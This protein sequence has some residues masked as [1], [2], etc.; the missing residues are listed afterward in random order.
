[1][2]INWAPYVGVGDCIVFIEQI[3]NFESYSVC[4]LSLFSKFPI[5][6]NNSLYFF[7]ISRSYISV[8]TITVTK[9][10]FTGKQCV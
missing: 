6:F 1:M 2:D 8:I 5:L 9:Y 10:K 7:F 3:A 4:F